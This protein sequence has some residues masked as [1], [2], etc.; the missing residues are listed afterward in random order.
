MSDNREKNWSSVLGARCWVKDEK[1]LR[2]WEGER[3]KQVLDSRYSV[4][5][6]K[7]EK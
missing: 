7:K 6:K 2:L 4:L 1:T 5:G 3:K